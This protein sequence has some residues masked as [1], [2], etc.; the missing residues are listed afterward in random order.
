MKLEPDFSVQCNKSQVGFFRL[1]CV[2]VA[3]DSACATNAWSIARYYAD[4]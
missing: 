3:S 1:P 2:E 4:F